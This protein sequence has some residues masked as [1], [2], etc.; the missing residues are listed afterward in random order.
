MLDLL[1]DPLIRV[2]GTGGSRQVLSLPG[3]YEEMVAD[4]VLGFTALRP[5]QRHAWHAFLAQLGALA[6]VRAGQKKA[7]PDA[8]EWH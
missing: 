1:T 8:S 3:V 4:R 5:H 2:D 7:L 6:L